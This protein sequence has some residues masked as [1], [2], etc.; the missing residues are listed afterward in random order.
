MSAIA[1]VMAGHK[2]AQKD[3]VACGESVSPLS[4]PPQSV[5]E[6]LV[7]RL[8]GVPK[9][10]LRTVLGD[11]LGSRVWEQARGRAGFEISKAADAEVVAALIRHLGRRAAEELRANDRQA[12]FVRLTVFREDGTSAN[13]RARLA[14]LTQD[15]DEIATAAL[16]MLERLGLPAGEVRSLGLDVTAVATTVCE[17]GPTP[18][19][20]ATLATC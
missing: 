8:R 15:P 12:K 13:G 19:W 6:G 7:S 16:C 10:A 11:A 2:L 3:L 1:N 4:S 20:Q 14:S 5:S 18:T 17:P 9:G